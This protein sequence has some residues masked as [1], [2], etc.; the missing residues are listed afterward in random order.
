MHFTVRRPVFFSIPVYY[1]RQT[2]VSGNLRSSEN[3]C[4]TF[5]CIMI[6]SHR[7]GSDLSF[8]CRVKWR[9]LLSLSWFAVLQSSHTHNLVTCALTTNC[10]CFYS[11]L[12]SRLRYSQQS[13]RSSIKSNPR[14]PTTNHS[15]SRKEYVF[16]HGP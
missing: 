5:A 9:G 3:L 4:L 12:A 1:C 11:T 2:E 13:V 14:H 6:G 10:D 16:P 7:T 15:Q 8:L